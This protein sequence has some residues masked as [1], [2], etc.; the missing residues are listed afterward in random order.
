MIGIARNLKVNDLLM[1]PGLMTDRLSAAKTQIVELQ[2]DMNNRFSSRAAK[3]KTI[4]RA[5]NSFLKELKK[6]SD[7]KIYNTTKA[8]KTSINPKTQKA[9]N[10]LEETLAKE[11]EERREEAIKLAKSKKVE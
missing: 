10:E 4:Y 9:I 2:Q 7:V 8:G 6:V 11:I 5:L 3:S 1:N